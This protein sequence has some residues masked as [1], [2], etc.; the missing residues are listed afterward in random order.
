MTEC[1]AG[2]PS[3]PSF[4]VVS[5]HVGHIIDRGAE[6]G[7]ANHGAVGTSQTSFGD[8]VPPGVLEVFI[9][10]FLNPIG[11]KPPDL[12]RGGGIYPALSFLLYLRRRFYRVELSQ[13]RRPSIAT[14]LNQKAVAQLRQ[15]Q[16]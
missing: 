10:Q 12:L 16:V 15:C 5:G 1:E 9:Q 11:V 7:W 13:Y 8:V 2:V 14:D 3:P 4:G 6:A